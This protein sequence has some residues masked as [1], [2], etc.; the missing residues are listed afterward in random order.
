MVRFCGKAIWKNQVAK[1]WFG[2]PLLEA[3]QCG[4]PVI[5]S[6]TSS[7][8]EVIGEA[9]IMIDPQDGDALCQSILKIYNSTE[10]RQ[11][12]SAYSLAQASKFSWK[13]C[14]EQTINTY[15]V[16]LLDS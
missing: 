9:G 7:L 14:A 12:M 11:K 1:E 13:K 8:P 4:V 5:T 6:N 10:L 15:K 16:A 2:L 3:I